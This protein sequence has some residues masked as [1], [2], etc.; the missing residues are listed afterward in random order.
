MRS[1]NRCLNTALLLPLMVALAFAASPAAAQSTRPD[2]GERKHAERLRAEVKDLD[3]DAAKA[4][5][6]PAGQRRVTEAIAKQF[7][8]QDSVVTSLRDRKM[9][10]GEI[11]TALA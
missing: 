8:G 10:H 11:T 2:E 1:L 4:T 6:T 3:A 7:N 5:A 9:G